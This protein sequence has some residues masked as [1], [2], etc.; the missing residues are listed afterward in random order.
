[1]R[2]RYNNTGK[3]RIS[4]ILFV[5]LI[6]LI[7][8]CSKEAGCTGKF[9]DDGKKTESGQQQDVN[10]VTRTSP[11]TAASTSSNTDSTKKVN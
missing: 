4:F 9:G 6:L 1:M 11:S 7:A 5:F 10:S 8:G 3:F 2:L